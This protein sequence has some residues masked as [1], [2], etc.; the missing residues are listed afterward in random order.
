[1]HSVNDTEQESAESAVVAMAG[2][3]GVMECPCAEIVDPVGFRL[4]SRH[5]AG[6]DI[7]AF[8]VEPLA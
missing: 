8:L 1:M 4:F 7:D 6:G 3:R 5:C 2:W